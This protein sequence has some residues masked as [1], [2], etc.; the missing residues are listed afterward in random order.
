MISSMTRFACRILPASE[1]QK[2]R[3]R[4]SSRYGSFSTS[5]C[6]RAAEKRMERPASSPMTVLERGLPSSS[7]I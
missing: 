5:A 7:E 6:S 1:R 2:V 3:N 4:P